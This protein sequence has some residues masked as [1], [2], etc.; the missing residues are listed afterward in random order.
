MKCRVLRRR[1]DL[2][3]ATL[4][5]IARAGCPLVESIKG[6]DRF[7]LWIQPVDATDWLNRS[8]GVVDFVGANVV[9]VKIR[10]AP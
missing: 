1:R 9:F 2:S 5:R 3:T 4:N 7:W 6:G 8:A 10:V